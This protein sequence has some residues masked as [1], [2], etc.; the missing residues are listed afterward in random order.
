MSELGKWVIPD[1]RR[2]VK[3]DLRSFEMIR[4]AD[5]LLPVDVSG[6]PVGSIYDVLLDH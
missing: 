5:W 3:R 6:K 2:D 4:S 1:F